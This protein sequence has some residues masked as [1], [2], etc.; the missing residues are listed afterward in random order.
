MKFISKKIAGAVLFSVILSTGFCQYNWKLSKDK[1][2]IKVY[3]SETATSKFKSVKVE[4]TLA[5]NYDKL[6]AALT[7]VDHLKDW[8]YNTKRSNVLK[9]ISPYELYYYSETS[10]PWPMSN[11]DVVIHV[12]ITR[13]SLRRFLKVV[14]VNAANY[15]PENDGKVRVPHLSINWY[16]TMP[17]SKTI[18][19]VY[20]FEA[21]PGG[22]LPGWLVN[23]FADRGPYETFKKLAVILKK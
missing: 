2:G 23:M 5:G 18:S 17:T 14:S 9:K 16:V 3:L 7:D 8:V 19:I 21:D 10:I 11:R 15:S 6:I 22:S 20:V 1:D 13:D 12:K 4:C